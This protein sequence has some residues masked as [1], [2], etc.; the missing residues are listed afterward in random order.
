M[1]RIRIP[2][3]PAGPAGSAA[4]RVRRA[5]TLAEHLDHPVTGIESAPGGLA[6]AVAQAAGHHPARRRHSPRF[7]PSKAGPKAA[8]PGLITMCHRAGL[9]IQFAADR[10]DAIGADRHRSER[11]KQCWPLHRPLCRASWLARWVLLKPSGIGVEAACADPTTCTRSSASAHGCAPPTSCRNGR[12][13]GGAEF[14]PPRDC[15]SRFSTK[16]GG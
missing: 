12:A 13:L 8:T 4:S 5:Q 16:G 7:A 9:H 10:G 14:R 15:R 2:S 6:Q 11:R 3:Q 1:P